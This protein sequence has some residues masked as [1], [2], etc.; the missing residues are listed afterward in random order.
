MER[1]LT[2]KPRRAGVA[3]RS[4]RSATAVTARPG[5]ASAESYEPLD[6]DRPA[7]VGAVC[8][9]ARA[10][11]VQ[12]PRRRQHTGGTR[13]GGRP[14]RSAGHRADRPRRAL[15]GGALRRG[16][17]GTRRADG[18][19]RRAVARRWRPDRGPRSAGA[20]SAGAGPRAG[21]ISA[22]VASVGDGASGRRREGQ[23][24]LRLRR[25]D[26]GGRRALAHPDR[27]P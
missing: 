1:V 2:G 19:R 24:A 23:A 9:V 10:F 20:A 14:A 5:R 12:L 8:R 15:R 18:V 16:G 13:R 17:Q 3:H 27:M 25:A 6:V 26:R 21:G 7:L 4:S 11:G 22:A